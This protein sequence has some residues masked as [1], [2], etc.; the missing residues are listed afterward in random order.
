MLADPVEAVKL[1]KIVKSRLA[2]KLWLQLD[3]STD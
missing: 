3:I 2:L 1:A